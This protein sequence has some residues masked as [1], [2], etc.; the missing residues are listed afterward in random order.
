[1]SAEPLDSVS[2]V[3]PP[4]LPLTIGQVARFAR[5]PFGWVMRLTLG[6]ALVAA[7]VGVH[8]IAMSWWPAIRAAAAVMPEG[9]E[10]R[11]GW[12][13]WPTNTVHPLSENRFLAISA[14]PRGA[15]PLPTAADLAVE[16]REDGVDVSS[17]L[18]YRFIPYPRQLTFGLGSRELSALLD[19]WR[20]HVFAW[21]GIAI[22]LALPLLWLTSG[23]LLALPLLSYALLGERRG[24]FLGC[25]RLAIGAFVPG[26]LLV[27]AM[28]LFYTYQQ[29]ALVELLLGIGVG[30]L[31]T[32]I[33]LI[34]APLK[35]P[36]SAPDEV[37]EDAP[38]AGSTSE[39][40][41]AEATALPA[42]RENP[43]ASPPK[44][45]RKRPANPFAEEE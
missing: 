4:G 38:Q 17:L 3:R 30:V 24:T 25:W 33:L 8:F 35:L 37:A 34:V 15:R 1:M 21:T 19:A 18:G 31:I 14:V 16:L 27:L 12:L 43:F 26:T 20:P 36:T 5:A 22:V 11:A 2:T 9:A 45:D 7:L 40:A 44:P 32:V 13:I 41:D 28:L 23:M 10:F 29:V 42:E 6:I 39:R